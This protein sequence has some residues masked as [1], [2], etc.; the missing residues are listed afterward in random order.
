[1][2]QH[3]QRGNKGCFIS[4]KLWVLKNFCY[5]YTINKNILNM[6]KFK[7]PIKDSIHLTTYSDLWIKGFH[8]NYKGE[9]NEEDVFIKVK[10]IVVTYK[11]KNMGIGIDIENIDPTHTPKQVMKTIAYSC[12]KNVVN[13]SAVL[14]TYKVVDGVVD[15]SQEIHKHHKESSFPLFSKKGANLMQIDV[16]LLAILDIGQMYQLNNKWMSESLGYEGD[17]RKRRNHSDLFAPDS[18]L[19]KATEWCSESPSH[20]KQYLSPLRPSLKQTELELV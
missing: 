3:P 20:T 9:P 12:T 11:N 17:W 15:Y 2:G 8:T 5:I 6:S 19:A 1:M 18:Y 7:K 14:A 16:N 4:K 13:I 10:Q